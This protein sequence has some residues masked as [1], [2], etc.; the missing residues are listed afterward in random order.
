[1]KKNKTKNSQTTQ[2]VNSSGKS[3]LILLW[4]LL[5]AAALL[6]LELFIR[7]P[8]L[9]EQY[10]RRVFPVVTYLPR[11]LM[12]FLPFSLAEVFVVVG[13]PALVLGAAFVI[14]RLIAKPG[15]AAFLLRLGK[16]ALVLVS[17]AIPIFYLNFGYTYHRLPLA[18]NLELE[19][20]D[21]AKDDLHATTL[22]VAEEVNQLAAAMPRDESGLFEPS[23][24]TQEILSLADDAYK[25]RSEAGG[26]QFLTDHFHHGAVLT[27]PVSLSRVWS[28]TGITGIYVPF[29]VES[30]VNIDTRPDEMM[31][32]ALHEVAHSYGIAR[33]DEANFLAFYCGILHEDPEMR[34][35]SWL[36]GFTHL[37]NA[38]Y[39]ASAELHAEIYASLDPLAKADLAARNDYWTKFEGPVQEVSSSVNNSYLIANKQEDG[40]KSYG[41]VVDLIIAY[42]ADQGGL[43]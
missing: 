28:Y 13:V 11:S 20:R 41:R 12:N 14:V 33:E 7:D 23:L 22:W 4:L 30:S 24:T 2:K 1:M 36:M 16:V 29:L 19:T 5:P 21:R 3:W 26:N 15:R 38:L 35:A 27:K 42:Y 9:A 18:D 34:Y 43:D 32:T 6:V 37:N 8:F 25:A 17:L 40:V 31:F 39:G 10:A